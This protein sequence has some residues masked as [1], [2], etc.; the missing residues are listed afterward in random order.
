MAVFMDSSP[1]P[2]FEIGDPMSPY[3]FVLIM[4]VLQMLLSQLIEQ[5][6]SFDFHWKCR[7]I[8]LFQLC[9]A[10][11]LLLFCNIDESSVLV[12]QHGLQKFANL[13]GL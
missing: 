8:D 12:F 9:F 11:D 7:E 4:E 10:D 3:L 5:D 13:S 1:E 6:S 2:G